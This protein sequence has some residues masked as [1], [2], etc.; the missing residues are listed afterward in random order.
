[1]LADS[2]VRF[3]GLIGCGLEEARSA[4]RLCQ[5]VLQFGRL[6]LSESVL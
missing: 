6:D 3:F 1:M 4:K 2:R 5:V